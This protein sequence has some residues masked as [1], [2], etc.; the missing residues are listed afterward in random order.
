MSAGG[1]PGTGAVPDA[2]AVR[3]ANVAL[4]RRIYD[5]GFNGGDPDVFD[6]CYDP[7]FV[8]HSKIDHDV[9][10]GA[11]GEKASMGKFRAAIP[12]VHFDIV[13][14]MAERDLVAVRLRVAGT[15]V[16][17]YSSIRAGSR[18]SVHA[19]ALFRVAGGRAVEEWFFVDAGS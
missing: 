4:V 7:A 10:P 3:Q 13:D 17:D 12:D 5:E 16:A 15:P 8:H 1:P 14:V 6:E 11:A 2:D 18:Y 19:V 9:V